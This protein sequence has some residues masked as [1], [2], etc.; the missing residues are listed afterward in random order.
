MKKL[1]VTIGFI[2][3][4]IFS[5]LSICAQTRSREDI[6]KEIAAKRV[7]L[8]KLE[9]AFLAPTE[10]DRAKYAEFLRQPDTG[11]IRLLPRDYFDKFHFPYRRPLTIDGGGAFYSFAERTHE[12]VNSAAIYLERGQLFSVWAGGNYSLLTSLGDIPI[13]NVSSDSPA[14]QFLAQHIPAADLEHARAEQRRWMEG[15]TVE[16]IRYNYHLTATLN[17]TY[18][19]RSILYDTADTL[20]TFKI[21]RVDDDDVLTIA[22]KLLRKYPTPYMS[23][24]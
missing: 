22:W 10:E 7:E 23:R 18:V 14:V 21:V 2:I 13:E 8:N 4:L 9:N 17:T 3:A 1:F 6:V 11:L 12:Y 15:A 5:S 20:V 19:L 16:G 24:N